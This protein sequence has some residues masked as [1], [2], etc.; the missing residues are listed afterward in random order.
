MCF[1]SCKQTFHLP[2]GHNV[3]ATVSCSGN[4]LHDDNRRA[5]YFYSFKFY[6][7]SVLKY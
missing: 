7:H 3:K 4:A 2:E 6:L 1:F 5:V